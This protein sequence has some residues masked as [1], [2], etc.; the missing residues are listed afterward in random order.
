MITP[1]TRKTMI[2]ALRVLLVLVLTITLVTVGLFVASIL[3]KLVDD[4]PAVPPSAW[5]TRR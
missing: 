2:H 5:R 1:N 3:I 4:G